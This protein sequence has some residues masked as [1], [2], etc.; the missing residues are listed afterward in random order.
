MI[1]RALTTVGC[2]LL[3][4]ACQAP[5][6]SAPTAVSVPPAAAPAAGPAQANGPGSSFAEGID[7]AAG[8]VITGVIERGPACFQ[9]WD[10]SGRCRQYNITMPADGTLTVS[11]RWPSAQGLSNPELFLVAPDGTWTYSDGPWPESRLGVA[12]Q[13]GVRYRIVIIAYAPLQEFELRTEV[14]P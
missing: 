2:L 8:N 14:Q 11:L 12:T 13:T 7:I 6:P 9:N 3:G 10:A 1:T 5:L 4:V